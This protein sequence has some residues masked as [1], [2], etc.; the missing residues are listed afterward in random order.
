MASP[1]K[2]VISKTFPGGWE[3]LPKER[4]PHPVLSRTFYQNL[5]YR[6]KILTA[7]QHFLFK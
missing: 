6:H 4:A 5:I 2:A 1:E 3:T 7:H